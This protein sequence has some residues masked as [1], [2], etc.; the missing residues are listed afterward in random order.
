MKVAI[1]GGGAAGFFA[2]I[3]VKDNFPNATV[4]I[5]EKSQKVLSKVKVSGGGRCNVTNG[6]GGIKEL[7]A[8]YPR[9]AN[10]LK[11][12]FGTFN[13]HQTMT[14][15]QDRGVPLV[16][17]EDGCVFPTSQSSQSII[18]F[19]LKDAESKSVKIVKGRGVENIHVSHDVVTLHFIDGSSEGFDKTIITT[20]GSP[21]RSGL[22]WLEKLGHKIV[23]PVPS[24]FTFNM[25]NEDVTDLMGVVV[26]KALVRIQGT[27]IRTYGPLLITHWG[28]SGP[29]V[30]KASA[31]GARILSELD[32]KF[33]IQINW[34]NTINEADVLKEINKIIRE[35]PNRLLSNVRPYYI[36]ERLWH[37]ML[38]RCGVS[39][40]I[41]WT[42]LGDKTKNKLVH[43]LTNDQ[44]SVV[45]KT[46]FK[47]EFVTCGGVS[48]ES[49]DVKSMRSKSCN[50]IYFAGEVLD[51][52][53]ITGGFNF[54]AAWT[55]AYIASKLS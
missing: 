16:I 2:A 8:A 4:I 54:Q 21:K 13:N 7:S 52:D 35:F 19:F 18:D 53:G 40:L 14:W 32:Y 6:C 45:G 48:L 9:G 22:N 3:N 36:P 43:V 41:K 55:T 46:T 47:E 37:Y 38:R 10:Q 11:K 17:Q 20:G 49:V 42:Q 31:F 28:M 50:N 12:L 27:N 15:F 29:A 25:P 51:I 5:F 26:E 39:D 34:V 1:V 33:S 44:Y 24:L 30:L 23:D